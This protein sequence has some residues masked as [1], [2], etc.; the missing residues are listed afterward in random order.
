MIDVKTFAHS[1]ALSVFEK[2]DSKP[3]ACLRRSSGILYHVVTDP[4][5]RQYHESRG[6]R[7]FLF[8]DRILPQYAEW[9]VHKTIAG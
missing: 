9:M 3:V 2:V 1:T 7:L 5:D 8:D 4:P 6:A